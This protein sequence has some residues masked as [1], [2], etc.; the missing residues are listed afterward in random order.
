M[1][2]AAKQDKQRNARAF[3][4]DPSCLQEYEYAT[5]GAAARIIAMA[6]REQ[7]HRLAAERRAFAFYRRSYRI[8][9][10]CSLLC[11]IVLII[12]CVH[13]T[14]N[15]HESMASFLAMSGFSGVAAANAFAYVTMRA[16]M[17][18][19][20]ALPAEQRRT[21]YQERREKRLMRKHL[22]GG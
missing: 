19:K 10:L 17:G 3:L 5:E 14:M 2:A 7:T 9:Q 11:L 18:V 8:G 12:A 4:P 1:S 22:S 6:E 21:G 20:D 13:L 15:D 16:M